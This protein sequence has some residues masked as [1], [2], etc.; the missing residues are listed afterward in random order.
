MLET[1]HDRANYSLPIKNQAFLIY[2]MHLKSV[3]DPL[4]YE[5]FEAHL[6]TANRTNV[7]A[8][9]AYGALIAYYNSNQG[10]RFGI[11]YWQ[12]VLEDEIETLHCQEIH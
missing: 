5:K 2:N 1:L 3:Y 6:R 12:S 8:R 11:D 9:H 7:C 4:I 10:S